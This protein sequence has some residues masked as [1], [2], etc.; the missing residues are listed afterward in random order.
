MHPVSNTCD[1]D[2]GGWGAT[3]IDSLTT[4]IMFGAEDVVKR[5]L[6]FIS[7]VDFH[8]VAGDG[9]SIQ[10]F[11]VTIRHLGAMLSAHDLL[12]GPYKHMVPD[13]EL[14][15]GLYDQTVRLGDVLA[16]AFD[17][18]SGVPRNWVDPAACKTDG[19]SSN[20]VAGAGSMIL[21]FAKLSEITKKPDYAAKAQKAQSYLLSP[22]PPENEPYPGLLGSYINVKAGEVMG[23]SGSWG[24]LSDSF[25]EYLLKAYQYDP[26]TYGSY[27]D[28]WKLA[29]DSTIRHIAS[30]ALGHDRLTFLPSWD[31][32]MLTYSMDSLSWF[33]GGNFILGG[34]LTENATLT[35]FGL[36]IAEAAHF[37]YGSTATGLGGEHIIW[38]PDC[39]EPWSDKPCDKSSSIRLRDGTF[40]LR[41]E[42]VET[43]YYAYRATGDLK[44]QDWAWAAFEA[45]LAYCRTETGFSAISNVDVV[46]GG[47][48]LDVQESFLFAEMLKYIWL[49]HDD[50]SKAIHAG[51]KSEWVFNTEA[52]PFRVI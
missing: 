42:V 12:D 30:H 13:A 18:P 5:I 10:F 14:R 52:H 45:M 21:E 40:K 47:E 16:C 32:Q 9:T 2:F 27:L 43:W 1:D 23:K 11:E 49:I 15:Q 17:T 6:Q 50:G 38:S 36:S 48:K 35:K 3:T 22:F 37:V 24:A 4:A 28:R 19:G 33:A 51:A 8:S 34:M 46:D 26:S 29:A 7:T 39:R 20:T 25:Y 44:Y 41:P 31:D